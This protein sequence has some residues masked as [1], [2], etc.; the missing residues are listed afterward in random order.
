MKPFVHSR[1]KP[2]ALATLLTFAGSASATTFLVTNTLNVVPGSLSNAVTLAN[3]CTGAPHTIS[4]AIP[5]GPFVISPGGGFVLNCQTV[6]DGY[7]QAG[8]AANTIADPAG[9]SNAVILIEINATG[10]TGGNVFTLNAAGSQIRGLNIHSF[11]VPGNV[12]SMFGSGGIVAGNF[13]GT[14]VS[15]NSC[16]GGGM[17]NGVLISGGTLGGSAPADRNVIGCSSGYGANIT[18]ATVLGNLIG[19]GAAGASVPNSAE[20][21]GV[22][23][24]SF[25]GNVV[26]GP[27]LGQGNRIAH[28]NAGVRTF[29]NG[30]VTVSGN[31]IFANTLLGIDLAPLTNSGANPPVLTAASVTY[32][33]GS[34]T[35]SGT[36]NSF[37]N[38]TSITV[39]FFQN[40]T[41][42]DQ[43]EEYVGSNG[44]FST[45]SGGT[46]TFSATLPT[47]VRNPTVTMTNDFG[48]T[49]AFSAPHPTPEA[50]VS[51]SPVNFGTVSVGASGTTQPVTISN[52]G[53]GPM[54]ITAISSSS[55]TEFPVTANTCPASLA[56]TANCTFNVGF[57]PQNSGSRTGTVTILTGNAVPGG[58]PVIN[59][60][61]SGNVTSLP[62][63]LSFTPSSVVQGSASVFNI[64]LT[65]PN[66]A[67]FNNPNFTYPF[68]GGVVVDAT[69]NATVGGGC[70]AG[71]SP[72]P[73]PG[74]TSITVA[75]LA[76]NTSGA[77][78]LSV[79][80]T[81]STPGSYN[82]SLAAGGIVGTV[83]SAAVA[84]ALSNT[85]TLAVTPTPAPALSI[86]PVSLNL[87]FG[88][89][90]VLTTAGPQPVTL[91][92][93]GTADLIFT[94]P[95][96]VTGDYAKTTACPP[97]LLPSPA[98]GSSCTV[99]V[100][101]TPTVTGPRPGTLTFFSNAP[102]SPDTVI[103]SGTGSA[104]P[105]PV[106]SLAPTS[107]TFGP[108][109][110]GTTSASQ[111]A[112]LTN[113]GTAVLNIGGIVASGDFAHMT[114][115]GTSL[116]PSPGPGNS[117]SIDVT[118]TPIVAGTR[119]GAITI[120][121]DASG[122]PH[123]LS[124]TGT[125]SAPPVATINV[126]PSAVTFPPT[127]VGVVSA[128]QVVTISNTGGAALT[129]SAVQVVGAEFT[130][131]FNGCTAALSTGGS[132]PVKLVFAPAGTGTR[133][134]TLRII[135][136]A[137]TSPTQ[138]TLTGTGTSAP[139]GTL[140]AQPAAVTFVDQVV[141]T[142]SAS[143]SVAVSNTGVFPVTVASVS[144]SGDFTQT[145][146]CTVVAPSGGCTVTVVFTPLGLGTRNGAITI[147][148]DASNPSLS[149]SLLGNGVLTSFPVIELSAT[150]LG[151]GNRVMGVGSSAQVVTVRNTGGANLVITR[152]YLQGDFRQSND[153][154]AAVVPGAT[155][156]I[157]VGFVP[158]IPGTR[159]GKMFVESNA[160]AQPKTVD[161]AGTGCRFFNLPGSRISSLI[162]Q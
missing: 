87:N 39:D 86:T 61:G 109:S 124:L 68:P 24:N 28:N 66:G 92:N 104:V 55:P 93:T 19:I 132:C 98:P 41:G 162:C 90:T 137:L 134:A 157:D 21:V 23:P 13:L 43:G 120:T 75:G 11:N 36:L 116:P 107:L 133:I 25:S 16:T 95:F 59:L 125:G 119:T 100:S 46:G 159:G 142:S 27:A 149:V 71:F 83:L 49:S 148:S 74:A 48:Y 35:I 160:T 38:Q 33:A 144:V 136:N 129:I 44:P 141:G 54:P 128:E 37:S 99:N 101:F 113:T 8:A 155:C 118:F 111:P 72:T 115:C 85:A 88:S 26:G 156:R 20:G 117:C 9:G 47:V 57:S 76:I 126:S 40:L 62:T 143:Q 96:T 121:D 18:S 150:A 58:D 17:F 73:A 14:I 147:V 138:V 158:S 103:L 4:F 84:N 102:S 79:R 2:L 127:Q 15:G 146:N 42:L 80:V 12:I 65:N 153:C 22:G 139:S 10:I 145:N 94:A 140:D 7:S 45:N 114:T 108:Q 77:C 32:L 131:S 3:T 89:V 161:L 1:L 110:V 60:A 122:S 152:I 5:S 105:V 63:T 106:V 82:A 51:P 70:T 56:P 69:P 34:T 151:F 6:I 30:N 154:T 123:V 78:D 97:T 53:Q 67:S 91:T 112:T 52:I 81:S 130:V 50:A 29:S 135:S 31:D 64:N